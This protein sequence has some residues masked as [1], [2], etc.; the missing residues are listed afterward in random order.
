MGI[1]SLSAAAWWVAL[2]SAQSLAK[3][4]TAMI[5]VFRTSDNCA[6]VVE[7]LKGERG[8]GAISG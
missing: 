4:T 7:N 1:A 5:F 3:N 2:R 6:F 8:S